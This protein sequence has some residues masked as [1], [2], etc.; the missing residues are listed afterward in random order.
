MPD[1]PSFNDLFRVARDE[2]LSRN[3]RLSKE[4]VERAGAD[5]NVLVAAGCAA[6]DQVI[7][8]LALA[9]AGLFLGSAKGAAL[10]RL[11]FD[12][13]GLVR[14]PASASLGS[15]RFSTSLASATAFTLPVN[16]ILQASNG[17]QF[18]TTESG[19]FPLGSVGPITIAIRSVLAG[20]DQWAKQGAIT[21]I[22]SAIPS[23]PRD[24]QVTNTVATAGSDDAETDDQLRDRAR[25]FFVTARRGTGPAIEA[26]ALGVP[27]V[28][29]A[30][31][32]EVVDALGRPARIVQLVVADAFV[33]QFASLDQTP[34]RYQQQSQQL[35][36]LVFDSLA[37]TRPAGTFVQ[38]IMGAVVLQAVQLALT[39]TAGAD[40]NSAALQARA[41]TVN[42]VNGLAPGKPFVRNDLLRQLR[43]VP[44]LAYS[45]GEVVSPPGDVAPKVLQVLR[46]TL[47][48]VSAI[49]SQT[50]QPITTGSNPDA[51][52]PA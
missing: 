29:K 50:D 41:T 14:K 7:G 37:D 25:R 47:G 11:V 10:D 52:V 15:V 16:T 49:S 26:A 23:S 1:L 18:I 33:D 30:T 2:V 4:S 19:L 13:Y 12:R 17:I 9:Q 40:V 35:A 39:F 5:A 6:A 22:V 8:Q 20:A 34:P 27:G 45:G 21:S 46:T 36:S 31:V 44:G 42:Y 38:V 51:Y 24:L 3:S 28:R 32:F 48:M 43:L